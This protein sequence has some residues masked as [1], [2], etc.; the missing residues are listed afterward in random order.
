MYDF[1][2]ELGDEVKDRI[3]GFSGII[4]ARTQWLTNCN[5]YGIKSRKLKDCKPIDALF[6]DEPDIE[7][8][9]PKVFEEPTRKKTGG[10]TMDIPQTNR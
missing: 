3:T 10:P 2:Y 7:L 8:I 5:T 9:K 1:K 6:F 4:T